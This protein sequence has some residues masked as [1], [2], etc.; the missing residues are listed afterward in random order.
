M[1][2]K[3][4]NDKWK[5]FLTENTFKEDKIIPSKKKKRHKDKKKLITSESDSEDSEELDEM[6]GAGAVAGYAGPIKDEET[7]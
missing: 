4:I 2:Y 3:D 6:S 7:T 5:A 1:N